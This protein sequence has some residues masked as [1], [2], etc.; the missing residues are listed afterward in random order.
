MGQRQAASVLDAAQ[1]GVV[2]QEQALA[3]VVGLGNPSRRY[4]RTRHNI[5]RMVL[6][7]LLDGAAERGELERWQGAYELVRCAELGVILYAP[8]AY[9]NVC[10]EEVARLARWFK[11]APE[12]LLVLHDDLDLALGRLQA[13][14]GGGDAGH[15][16]VRSIT[17]HLGS[18]SFYRLRLGIGR[19]PAGLEAV[20][21]VL[22]PFTAAERELLAKVLAQAEHEVYQL[23]DRMQ[24][25]EQQTWSLS[26][27]G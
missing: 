25:G 16:G 3:I 1:E 23:L 27:C 12:R 2:L 17:Q 9:M 21:Y 20:D 24:R 10:G 22:Q 7:R 6:E 14:W 15:R 19:P 13:R 8:R 18:G 4:K 11:L 5:G 26:V